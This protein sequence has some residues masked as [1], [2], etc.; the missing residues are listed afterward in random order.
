MG[1]SNDEADV[2]KNFV[3]K[4]RI[5]FPLL[6]DPGSVTIKAYGLLNESAS[7]RLEGIPHPLTVLVDPSGVIRAKIGF[8][9]YRESQKNNDLI[10]AEKKIKSSE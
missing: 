8:E 5:E 4:R 9:G 7:G 6:S 3:A 10:A 2:L 1:I